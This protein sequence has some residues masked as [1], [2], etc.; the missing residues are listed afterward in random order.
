MKILGFILIIFGVI[1]LFLSM[2]MFGDIAI[3]GA[4]GAI[5]AILSGIGFLQVEK[6]L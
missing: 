4:I 5:T 1:S 6:R 3:A 2:A